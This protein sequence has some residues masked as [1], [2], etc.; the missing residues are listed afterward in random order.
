MKPLKIAFHNIHTFVCF[1]CVFWSC[2]RV[3]VLVK[4]CSQ[5]LQ[6]YFLLS[7]ALCLWASSLFLVV[8]FFWQ[9]LHWNCFWLPVWVL[10]CRFRFESVENCFPQYSHFCLFSSLWICSCSFR[11]TLL[12]KTFSQRS[13]PYFLLS[14][15]L[16]LCL[17]RF[18]TVEIC[19]IV[20]F[21]VHISMLL[22]TDGSIHRISIYWRHYGT[23]WLQLSVKQKLIFS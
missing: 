9:L 15:T 3:T 17:F 23:S 22:M 13:Q 8:K 18:E 12:V 5:R 19:L 7:W 20:F 1:L 10:R 2:S 6:P 21:L 16:C 14:W 11:V 4:T